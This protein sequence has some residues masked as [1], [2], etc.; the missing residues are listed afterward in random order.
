MKSNPSANDDVLEQPT[1][2]EIMLKR[3]ARIEGQIRGL[4]AMVRRGERFEA[5][6]QQFSASRS[7]LEKAYRL[8]LTALIEET[9]TDPDQNNAEALAK[10]REVFIRYT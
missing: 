8:M 7:A 4:Q 5:V 1:T 10:V 3:L 2:Q 6:A 9:L